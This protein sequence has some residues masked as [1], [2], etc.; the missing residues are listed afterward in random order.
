LDEGRDAAVAGSSKWQ[1]RRVFSRKLIMVC[2][3]NLF[4]ND[5]DSREELL[6]RVKANMRI[7]RK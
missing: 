1:A 3:R 6:A 5:N 4:P 7:S 2:Q